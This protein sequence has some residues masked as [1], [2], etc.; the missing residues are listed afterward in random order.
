MHVGAG[1]KKG[2]IFLAKGKCNS[3]DKRKQGE[4]GSSEGRQELLRRGEAWRACFCVVKN[5]GLKIYTVFAYENS[6]FCI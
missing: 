3:F 4:F 1:S 2:L 5:V 6:Y